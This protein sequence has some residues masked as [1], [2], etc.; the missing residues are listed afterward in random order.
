MKRAILY[1]TTVFMVIAGLA[2]PGFSVWPPSTSSGTEV[3]ASDPTQGTHGS[4]EATPPLEVL[5]NKVADDKRRLQALQLE[6]KADEQALRTVPAVPAK[7][8]NGN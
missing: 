8:S 1:T 7:T 5:E 3:L 2:I 4:A 6:L